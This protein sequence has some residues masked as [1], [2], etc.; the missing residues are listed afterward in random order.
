M[1]RPNILFITS[2][3]TGDWLRCYGHHTVHTPHLD[4]LAADGYLFSNA[5]CTSPVCTPSRGAMMTGRY[6]QSNGLMGLI[7]TPYRWRYHE[8]ER[9]LS[10]LLSGYGYHTVLFNHQHEAP[11]TDPLGFREQRLVDSGTYRLLTGEHVSTAEETATS[12]VEFLQ[13]RNEGDA[14]FYAQMGVFETHTPFGFSGAEPDDEFGVEIL[15][16]VVDDENVRRHISGLQGAIRHL[17]RAVGRIFSAL[18]QTGLA[19]NTIVVFTS[20]HGVELPRCKWE[21]YDGGIRTAL[22]MRWP[23]GSVRGGRVC[24]WQISNVDLV[25]TL[26]DFAHL[27]IPQNVQ[28]RS[29]ASFFAGEHDTPPRDATFAMMHASNR[30]TESRSIRTGQY[31]LIRNFSPS[32]LPRVPSQRGRSSAQER[33]VLELYDLAADPH[34]LHSVSR[35]PQYDTVRRDLDTRLLSWLQE[36]DDPILHGPVATPYYRM[37]IADLQR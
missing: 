24:D 29:F 30:W 11:H 32:R 13:Q 15:P 7:Q 9:H 36:V 10:H 17:D 27:P 28:G 35:T 5:F 25:P 4:A 3:D 20:D 2:H 1:Q 18:S 23:E 33:P 14:P 16:Y 37:A 6:P 22:L 19:D 8:G 21:L 31:K 26:L 34:E 12:V